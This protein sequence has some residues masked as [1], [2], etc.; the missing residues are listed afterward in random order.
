MQSLDAALQSEPPSPDASQ[1]V[2]D[3]NKKEVR[4]LAKKLLGRATAT[5]LATANLEDSKKSVVKMDELN[6]IRT[7]HGMGDVY[8][9]IKLI[10]VI[11][12]V[13][14]RVVDKLFELSVLLQD[15]IDSAPTDH[16]FQF[17]QVLLFMP[18]EKKQY[19]EELL[20]GTWNFERNVHDPIMRTEM[21]GGLCNDIESLLQ[22]FSVL[23]R[24]ERLM[25][26]SENLEVDWARLRSE[27]HSGEGGVSGLCF[28]D[29]TDF[30][31]ML[32]ATGEVP[33]CSNL[34]ER[35]RLLASACAV[36]ESWVSHF[37]LHR[38]DSK[39]RSWMD[40]VVTYHGNW[41]AG[42]G[43]RDQ[44]L[45]KYLRELQTG[46]ALALLVHARSVFLATGSSLLEVY[47]LGKSFKAD[48]NQNRKRL[49]KQVIG[50]FYKYKMKKFD[51]AEVQERV[52]LQ[53]LAMM[54]SQGVYS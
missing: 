31:D 51:K 21:V 37:H 20:A 2:C 46:I 1:P 7:T 47:K 16:F 30:L 41:D 28:E 43:D 26:F 32:K 40:R 14:S 27:V 50:L 48:K 45:M 19:F 23:Q 44:P 24:Y 33:S 18:G 11:A 22:A 34:S 4:S 13:R 39:P 17:H 3:A 9:K 5:I 54:A 36:Q 38:R 49:G 35:L 29:I 25:T 12:G 10:F 53:K 42:Y 8:A 6:A 15:R 52:T